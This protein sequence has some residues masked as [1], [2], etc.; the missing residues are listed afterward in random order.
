VLDLRGR[1]ARFLYSRLDAVA[2]SMLLSLGVKELGKEIK[3]KFAS[4]MTGFFT[5]AE[6]GRRQERKNVS[7]R[8][9][10]KGPIVVEECLSGNG[11]TTSGSITH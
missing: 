4:A 10:R 7:I 2:G 8:F 6:A 11:S 5:L 9:W 1:N 3:V